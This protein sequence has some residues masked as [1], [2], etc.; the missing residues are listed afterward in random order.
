MNSTFSALGFALAKV[1]SPGPRNL[2]QVTVTAGS[3]FANAAK[4]GGTTASS[5]TQT[6]SGSAT[7][8]AAVK[9]SAISRG[10]PCKNGPESAK[11]RNGG[12]L[13]V[14]SLNGEIFHSGF[15]L[16]G[17]CVV[18]PLE[19]MVQTIFWVAPKSSEQ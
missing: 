19:T 13:A 9:V 3:I 18:L 15:R 14:A 6:V 12:V 7:P 4:A 11:A 2:F 1:T 17:I 16:N 5:A 8:G 10:G